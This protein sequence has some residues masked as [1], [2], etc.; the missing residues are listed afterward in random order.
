M[1]NASFLSLDNQFITHLWTSLHAK[2]G[3]Q[4]ASLELSKSTCQQFYCFSLVGGGSI[5][6][7]AIPSSFHQG[8]SYHGKDPCFT[9]ALPS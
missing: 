2:F 4:D 8:A 9:N 5:V 1:K 6:K 3:H 7:G